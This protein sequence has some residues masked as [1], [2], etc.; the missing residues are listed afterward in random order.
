M[1]ESSDSRAVVLRSRFEP[2]ATA[3]DP[4]R[5]L[6]PIGLP[7]YWRIVWGRKYL[8]LAL[9][10]F[11][12]V[13]GFLSTIPQ[14]FM[15]SATATIEI[16]DP[17]TSIAG[18][19][20]AEPQSGNPDTNIATQMEILQ[21]HSLKSRVY[22]RLSRELTPS[23]PP[24]FTDY[25]AT[26][27]RI[28][29]DRLGRTPR[30]PLQVLERGLQTAILNLRVANMEGTRIVEIRTLSSSPEIAA[31]FVNTTA[32]EFAEQS[33]ESRLKSAQRVNQWLTNQIQAWKTKLE[34][35]EDRLQKVVQQS[36][37]TIPLPDQAAT[38]AQTKLAQLQQ[39]LSAIQTERIAKETAYQLAASGSIDAADGGALS[40]HR[41]QVNA[42][43]TQLAELTSYLTPE[44]Y[45]VKRLQVQLQEAEAGL[46]KERAL[47]LERLKKDVEAAKNRERSLASAYGG[48][49]RSLTTQSDKFLEYSLIKREV[50][51]NRQLY[52]AMVQQL[53]QTGVA[54][55]APVDSV[56][57]IDEAGPATEPANLNQTV[58]T[59]LG[60]ATGMVFGCLLSIVLE[61]ADRSFRNPGHA[62]QWLSIPEIAVIPST[63][64][65][66]RLRE[67]WRP[68][69][70]LPAKF[71]VRTPA[72]S[73]VQLAEADCAVAESFR[74]LLASIYKPDLRNM[75]LLV[76]SP[77]PRE[78]K[79]TVV[80]N[81]GIALS[82]VGKRVLLVDGDLRRPRLHHI[83]GLPNTIGL[84][85]LISGDTPDELGIPTD[86]PNLSVL[87]AGSADESVTALLYSDRLRELVAQFRREFDIV[88]V[89]APPVLSVA[90]ARVLARLSDGVLLVLR[91]GVTARESGTMAAQ[92]LRD[93]GARILGTIL[94]D[95][96]PAGN[97]PLR[98]YYGYLEPYAETREHA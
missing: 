17:N 11:G 14:I 4:N 30:D 53:N 33:L 64:R 68:Q 76:T 26:L 91:S 6:D 51:T 1:N 56:R 60:I 74:G 46:Q 2:G 3:F 93:D 39:E 63:S 92:Q 36:N 87:P 47:V 19:N 21:S 88:I 23:M 57:V 38:L 52:N 35:S 7:E 94:N 13:V 58:N 44:H 40:N 96:V 81:L 5:D 22:Q 16:R 97:H 86:R 78:G 25:L 98:N 29:Q 65:R 10:V 84:G 89:D 43:K 85:N 70:L 42:I 37:A 48:Q 75:V 90:D 8:I 12:A 67:R 32:S 55:A 80:S 49:A 72:S 59:L 82:Q 79:S 62:S 95:W 27:R 34:D 73:T 9:A 71:G 45:K 61:R 50:E 15:Y 24:P 28:V 31:A 69:R 66:E 54:F 20:Q 77:N 41:A 18:L 83:F